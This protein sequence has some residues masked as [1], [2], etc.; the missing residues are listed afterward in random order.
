MLERQPDL[1]LEGD[2]VTVSQ[3]EVLLLNDLSHP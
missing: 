1:G 3:V 2:G